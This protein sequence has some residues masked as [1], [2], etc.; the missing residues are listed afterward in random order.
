MLPPRCFGTSVSNRELLTNEA[1]SAII[2]SIA[3]HI[4]FTMMPATLSRRT[5]LSA[6][7]PTAALGGALS[8]TTFPNVT[9]SESQTRPGPFHDRFFKAGITDRPND[10]LCERWKAAGMDGM[11]V[12]DWNVSVEEARKRRILVEKHGL[13]IHSVMRGWTTF[14]EPDQEKWEASIETMRVALR[15]AAAYGANVVLFASHE[16]KPLEWPD[17]WNMEIDFDPKTLMIKSLLSGNNTPYAESIVKQNRATERALRAIE[18]LIPDAAKEGVILAL[19]NVRDNFW[20]TPE[21]FTAVIRHFDSL[22]VKAYFDFANHQAV[23]RC[24]YWLDALGS[25][26]VKIHVKD[27]RVDEVKGKRGGGPVT[28]TRAGHGS[29]DWLSVRKKLDEVRYHGW[30]TLEDGDRAVEESSKILQAFAK[31]EPVPTWN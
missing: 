15:S 8:A 9:A 31:G 4:N 21:F 19:E 22:W 10:A 2:A 30:L 12:R 28:M 3:H 18:T 24:E 16:L 23:A 5:F 17:R 29:T 26:I 27:H 11:E 6:V 20:C 1:L 14:H 7:L 13:R 25:E